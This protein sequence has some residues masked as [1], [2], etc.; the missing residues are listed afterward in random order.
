[1]L[2]CATRFCL[3]PSTN[4]Y[5]WKRGKRRKQTQMFVYFCIRRKAHS[6]P[7]YVD[8]YTK[9]RIKNITAHDSLFLTHNFT[10][11]SF[12]Y[13]LSLFRSFWYVTL[14][15]YLRIFVHKRKKE[16][17]FELLIVLRVLYFMRCIFLSS[18]PSYFFFFVFSHSHTLSFC[19]FLVKSS[20]VFFFDNSNIRE[21]T[22][23]RKIWYKRCEEE[24]H[25]TAN[26]SNSHTHI[27]SP[28]SKVAK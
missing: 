23:S 2:I 26:N 28:H 20:W 15:L 4:G 24:K 25:S 16:V 12:A 10:I 19:R 18:L 1:M 14:W 17:W 9:K 22:T 6:Y 11:T 5:F 27:H 13:S 8:T 21:S 7:L 3:I